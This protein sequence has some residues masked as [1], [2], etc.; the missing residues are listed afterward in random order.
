MNSTIKL[1]A[2][3]DADFYLKS[4]MDEKLKEIENWNEEFFLNDGL[5]KK[6]LVSFISTKTLP[7]IL[8][9]FP[10]Y[11]V[12]LEKLPGRR[13]AAMDEV[14]MYYVPFTGNINLLQLKPSTFSFNIDSVKASGTEIMYYVFA[15]GVSDDNVK[16]EF[17]D[18]ETRFNKSLDLIN[19][20]ISNYNEY[21]ILN[22]NTIVE[23]RGS[24]IRRRRNRESN[25]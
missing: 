10:N 25:L 6:Q 11:R 1:F 21:L 14:A 8:V 9:D 4:Y 20:S 17:R 3:R 5:I 22:A 18:F 15:E 12:K 16:K 24:E 19:N 7:V 2:G 23:S 13:G